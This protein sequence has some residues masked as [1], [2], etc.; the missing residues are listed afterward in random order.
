MKKKILEGPCYR[1]N[2]IGPMKYV[3]GIYVCVSCGL[4][5]LPKMYLDWLETGT[6]NNDPEDTYENVPGYEE[7]YDDT[8]NYIYCPYCY[9]TYTPLKL[10]FDL[11]VCPRCGRVIDD[12]ELQ[13]YI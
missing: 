9:N 7:L 8:G 12:E 6:G 4:S 5:S 11:I 2:C 13:N 10:Q 3:D 1:E